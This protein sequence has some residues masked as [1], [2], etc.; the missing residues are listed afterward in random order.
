MGHS[1]LKTEMIELQAGFQT[2]LG[3]LTLDPGN[4][5]YR[6]RLLEKTIARARRAIENFKR[7]S[8]QRAQ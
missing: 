1:M 4:L 6:A 7:R 3:M 2:G 8:D 5:D